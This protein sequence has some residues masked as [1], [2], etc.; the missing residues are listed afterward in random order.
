LMCTLVL[1][2]IIEDCSESVYNIYSIN[3]NC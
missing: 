2:D 1:Y 3:L